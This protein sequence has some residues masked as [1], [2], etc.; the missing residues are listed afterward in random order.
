[1]RMVSP[2]PS[3]GRGAGGEGGRSQEKSIAMSEKPRPKN[4]IMLARARSL[5]H[6]A[7]PP[8]QLLWSVL[9]GRR[10]AGLKFRRQELIEPYIVDFCCRE[11]KLIV[12]LDGSSHEDKLES[13]LKRTQ[14][15]SGQGY[16]VLRV[17][18]QDVREDL[19]AV[20]RYIAREAGMQWDG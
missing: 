6:K 11:L 17:T 13:D 18:N 12:E 2:L 14:W 8:E 20:A 16:R 4:P 3:D 19:E 7:T 9:R 10:L 1:M 5:R 15:L